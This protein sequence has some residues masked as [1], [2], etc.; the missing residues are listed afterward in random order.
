MTKP[1]KSCWVLASEELCFNTNFLS[2]YFSSGKVMPITRGAGVNQV[3]FTEFIDRE[4]YGDWVHLYP[5]GRIYQ[6]N[7]YLPK[8]KDGCWI[9][10][11]GRKSPPNRHLGPLKW[12]VGRLILES[13]V[14]PI[15]IP[16][17]HKGMENV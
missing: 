10:G 6:D 12:G 9:T 1:S 17:Y 3:Q 4:K 7:G 15:I 8:D 11:S 16:I 14:T 13:P 5:E 2:T